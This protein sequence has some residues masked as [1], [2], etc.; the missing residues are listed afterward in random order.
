MT[1]RLAW[2]GT[3]VMGAAMCRHLLAAGHEVAVHTRT[4]AR[5]Q[6]LVD[7]GARWAATPG[8]AAEG[9]EV[10]FS[11]VGYPED[12]REVYLGQSGVR[13]AAQAGAVWVD[14]TTSRPQLAVEL[15]EAA[16][17]AGASALDAPVSG[18]DVGARAATLSIMVG[19][20]ADAFAVVR[21]LLERLG[22]TIVH[23]GPSGA[24][25]HTKLVNQ[26]LIASNMIGVCEALVY[27][28]AAR[29]DPTAVLASV[30]GGAAASWSLA[31]LAPRILAGN[32]EPGFL[33]AHFLKDMAI[34]LDEARRMRLSLPGLAL[35][36]QL[37]LAVEAHGGASK[38]TQALILALDALSNRP[39][40]Q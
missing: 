22:K 17:A 34:A 40:A 20:E 31:N 35:A 5:A 33:V 15:A 2:I 7:A 16:R 13:A 36:E 14:M 3:G 24:G 18:G 28:R 26:I 37:Y 39:A 12:V 1:K 27:A 10:V 29:L 32:L 23:Q 9:A 38:G 21:P 19:G 30:G 4:R 6:P 25:Q 11:M 8:A